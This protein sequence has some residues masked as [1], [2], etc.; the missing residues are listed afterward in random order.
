MHMAVKSASIAVGALTLITTLA[1][2]SDSTATVSPATT[3]SA[4]TEVDREASLGLRSTRVCVLNSR[5]GEIGV[6]W[7][8]YD[9]TSGNGVVAA[10]A[11]LCG[12][13]SHSSFTPKRDV[14]GSASVEGTDKIIYFQAHNAFGAP[15][16]FGVDCVSEGNWVDDPFEISQERTYNNCGMSI[17]VT[18]QADDDWINFLI[19]VK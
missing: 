18:R 15:P 19:S 14:E 2:C 4:P 5:T 1:A 12:E 16:G 9:T 8:Q 13:G 6:Q 3:A 11:Q 10:G 7:S 17:T